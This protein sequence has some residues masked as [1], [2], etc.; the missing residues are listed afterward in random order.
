METKVIF[1]AVKTSGSNFNGDNTYD[2]LVINLGN[3]FNAE[4]GT[5]VVPVSGTY[6]MSFSGQSAFGKYD[7]TEVY[8]KKNES[9]IFHIWDSNEVEKADAN[10]VSYTW[11]MNLSQGDRVKLWSHNFLHADEKRY[12]ITFTG[13]LIHV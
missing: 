6:R 11:L 3:G 9:N 4:S 5:F 1:S 10:N 12:H 2:D 13:E 8:V 7:F